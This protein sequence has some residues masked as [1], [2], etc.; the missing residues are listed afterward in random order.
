M[1]EQISNDAIRRITALAQERK[2]AVCI[3]IVDNAGL[4]RS[5]LRM[6]GAVAGAIDVS[7]KK[8]R[9][10]AL[11][12]SDSASLGQEARPGGS[13]YSLESTNGGLISFG[14]GI[15]LRD[16]QGAILGAVGVAG[17]TVDSDQ[18]LALSG[19]VATAAAGRV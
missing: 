6:D 9:T 10:A 15:V 11:F 13:I 8:A 16:D 3:S 4:L 2:Q 18:Q 1:F 19:A 12:G 7:I 5:F 14:G 17:A